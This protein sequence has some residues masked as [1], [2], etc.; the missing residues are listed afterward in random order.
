MIIKQRNLQLIKAEPKL[1]IYTNIPKFMTFFQKFLK[2]M[3]DLNFFQLLENRKR[4]PKKKK[5]KKEF[6]KQ[7][8][9]TKHKKEP[10][11]K[12]PIKNVSFLGLAQYPNPLQVSASKA[13]KQNIETKKA[14]SKSC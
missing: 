11:S 5:K 10:N 1:S 6:Q 12:I 3:Q 7:K 9:K 8:T 4:N 2:C 14:K 13:V